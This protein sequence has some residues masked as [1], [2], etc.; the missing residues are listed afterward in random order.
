VECPRLKLLNQSPEMDLWATERKQRPE[1]SGAKL[2]KSQ[3]DPNKLEAKL[4]LGP[5]LNSLRHCGQY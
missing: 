1:E 4:S 3:S 2:I 5:R